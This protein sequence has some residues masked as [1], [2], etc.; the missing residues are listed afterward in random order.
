MPEHAAQYQAQQQNE[1]ASLGHKGQPIEKP[2][3]IDDAAADL[4]QGLSGFEGRR[5]PLLRLAALSVPA[6]G[7]I[8]RVALWWSPVTG[9][10]YGRGPLCSSAARHNARG[11]G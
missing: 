3:H 10:D 4:A 1:Q 6:A 9:Q 11:E 8:H 2:H 5:P 7:S